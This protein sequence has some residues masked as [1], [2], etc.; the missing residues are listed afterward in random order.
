MS[1][2]L[3]LFAVYGMSRA[4]GNKRP[5]NVSLPVKYPK[6]TPPPETRMV[7]RTVQLRKL[8]DKFGLKTDELAYLLGVKTQ[9]VRAYLCGS[10][11]IPVER[12]E[13]VKRAVG[14]A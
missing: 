12:L 10:R 9:T 5:R 2:K 14:K 13:Q 3:T 7:S 4:A 11:E 1:D 8:V 6:P